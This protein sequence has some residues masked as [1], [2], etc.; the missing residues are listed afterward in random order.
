MSTLKTIAKGYT[1][2]LFVIAF[3]A[4]VPVPLILCGICNNM[5]FLWLYLIPFTFFAYNIGLDTEKGYR[6]EDENLK[7]NEG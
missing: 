3:Y 7:E 5:N 4:L 2:L 6:D 1:V